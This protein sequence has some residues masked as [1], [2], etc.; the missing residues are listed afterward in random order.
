MKMS[1]KMSKSM[2][3][4]YQ[5]INKSTTNYT[6]EILK[7]LP[8]E[9]KEVPA[10]IPHGDMPGDKIEIGESHIAKANRIFPVLV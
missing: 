7:V 1:N 6:E 3:T 8:W 9:T 4:N 5:K 10:E 2:N